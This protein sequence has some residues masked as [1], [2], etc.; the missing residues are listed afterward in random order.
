MKKIGEDKRLE[1][2]CC[3]AAEALGNTALEGV[4]MDAIVEA[5]SQDMDTEEKLD[6]IVS[7]IHRA[8]EEVAAFL[9]EVHKNCCYESKRYLLWKLQFELAGKGLRG[10]LNNA[11][12]KIRSQDEKISEQGK[13]CYYREFSEMR[14]TNE[15]MLSVSIMMTVLVMNEKDF[16]NPSDVMDKLLALADA[17]LS[18]TAKF[19][20][21]WK[22][23]VEDAEKDISLERALRKIYISE[24]KMKMYY[25][26]HKRLLPEV[27]AKHCVTDFGALV[28][29][30]DEVMEA[31][32]PEPDMLE[33]YYGRY[34]DVLYEL[35]YYA[36]KCTEESVEEMFHEF[37]RKL[38]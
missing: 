6:F 8:M 5:Q 33:L 10:E 32:N 9:P 2:I 16:E 3:L 34:L 19:W 23:I 14:M 26:T 31:V 7:R 13:G 35:E 20:K 21:K 38:S 1:Q 27:M 17:A 36:F 22:T 24:D 25:S 4:R 18:R 30:Q 29:F 37:Y 11:V 12:R 15:F 28:K